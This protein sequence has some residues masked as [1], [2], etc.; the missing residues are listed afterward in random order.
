MSVVVD[1]SISLAWC[2][3][4]ERTPAVAS[5]LQ[6]V[7]QKGAV[8]PTLWRY[9]VANGLEM[10]VRRKR[11]DAA[12]RDDSL[13]DLSLLDIAVDPESESHLWSATVRIA[14]KHGLTVYDATYL[15][16]AQRRRL[17]LATLDRALVRA[18]QAESVSAIGK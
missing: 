6:Q 15:E 3:E 2:F 18:C 10:G 1:S 13:A 14:E 16:L 8:V 12:F 17:P 9:E 4:D 7:I 5:V 11:I